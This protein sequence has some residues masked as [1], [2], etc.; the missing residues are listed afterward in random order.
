MFDTNDLLK[1][2]A[3]KLPPTQSGGKMSE[4]FMAGMNPFKKV[5]IRS[6]IT[7]LGSSEQT[8]A[9]NHDG[10]SNFFSFFMGYEDGL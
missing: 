3:E 10:D 8:G 7:A 6:H 1:L 5:Y 9:R 4:N 2:S